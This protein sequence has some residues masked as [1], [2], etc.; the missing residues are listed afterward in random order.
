LFAALLLQ[1]VAKLSR[2]LL[3]LLYRRYELSNTADLGY[4]HERLLTERMFTHS[5]N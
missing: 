5:P 3:Q 1:V 2:K 4:C